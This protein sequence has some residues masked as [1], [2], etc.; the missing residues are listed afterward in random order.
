[1]FKDYNKYLSTSLKVYLFVLVVI[2]ILKLVGL[3]YFGIDYNNDLVNMIDQKLNVPII[4]NIIQFILLTVQ[5]YFL[6]YIAI[7][8]KPNVLE[9]SLVT[10]INVIVTHFIFEYNLDYLYSIFSFS[11][12]VGYF[13]FKK[14]SL[15]RS[16]GVMIISTILQIISVL[17]RNDS[18]V[19]YGFTISIIL[20]IDYILMLI[21]YCEVL[22]EGITLCQLRGSSSQKKINF[23]NLL[24][25]L[26]KNLHNFSEKEKQEKLEIII[27]IILSTL[28]NTLS[29]ALILLVAKLNHTLIECLFILTSFWLTKRTFGKSFHLKSMS[30]CFI[31][32]NLTYYSLNRI[33]TPL[34]ISIFVPIILGVGL[35]YF[36]SKLVK[37]TYKTLYRGM[38]KELFEET[39]LKV[40]D[41][42]SDKYKI[43]YDFYINKKSDLSLSFQY[44][45]TVSGIRKIRT[46]LNEKIK[47]LK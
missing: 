26:Q 2:F 24:K 3:D 44:N 27:F 4:N 11:L 8:N 17:T 13:L 20:D 19:E 29:L 40:V 22:K 43:C 15:K 39:I 46:R 25:K 45:Y 36:T 28:W 31:V 10:L 37:K 30:Q 6:T 41:K 47:E 16:F 33:T 12:A 1:M 5:F 14:V 35:S 38:P 21:I 32:S 18:F 42:N 34:G 9:V 7:K 23:K